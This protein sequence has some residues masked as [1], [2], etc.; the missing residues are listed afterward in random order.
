MEHQ[1]EVF[2]VQLAGVP[3]RLKT[4]HEPAVVDELVKLVNEKVE[5][6]LAENS[7]LSFQKA[8]LL[9][10]LHLAEDAVVVKRQAVAELDRLEDN[11]KV[12]L[13]ELESSPISKIRMEG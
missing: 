5:S 4:S 9:A 1:K 11:A 3:M 13:S 12:I 7:Q 2:E 10:S 6:I 8:L